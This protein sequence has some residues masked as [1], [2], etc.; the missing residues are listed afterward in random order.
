MQSY[1]YKQLSN[2]R[3]KLSEY[4]NKELYIKHLKVGRTIFL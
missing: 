3:Y 1:N 4:L 2:K